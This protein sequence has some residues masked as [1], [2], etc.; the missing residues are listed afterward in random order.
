MW[1]A[2]T[3]DARHAFCFHTAPVLDLAWASDTMLAT[4]STDKLIHLCGVGSAA[5]LRTLAG[6][7]DEVNSVRW[8]PGS[9]AL[10]AS[11]SDDTSV[12]LWSAGGEG[13]PPAG[14]VAVCSGHRKPVYA[15]RWAPT[16]EGTANA[17]KAAMLARC[18]TRPA[19]F[20]MRRP[21]PPPP[22]RAPPP[23]THTLTPR[24]LPSP[25]PPLASPFQ[26]LL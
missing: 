26:L 17:G 11:G 13:A 15:V 18:G 5:P 24:P 20:F 12:R 19:P 7:T 23:H 1:D 14:C 4:C 8:S 6:H 21:P 2:A 9:S 16:G 25:T 22:P 3:G 10:L